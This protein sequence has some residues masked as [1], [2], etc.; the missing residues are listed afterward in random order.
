MSGSAN[1]RFSM[2]VHVLTMLANEEPLPVSSDAAA[3]SVG[4]NA[5]HLRRIMGPLRDAGIVESR[6]GAGGGWTL[7]RPASRIS[8]ADV[9]DASYGDEGLVTLHPEPNPA[10]A[11]GAHIGG[12]L[13]DLSDRATRAART[14]LARTT[15]EDVR[16]ATLS[17]AP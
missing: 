4:T 3:A 16:A 2:A 14:E 13:E 11:V 6:P 5:A 15:L 10:C 8:M 7:G 1:T 12:V 17:T 9:W